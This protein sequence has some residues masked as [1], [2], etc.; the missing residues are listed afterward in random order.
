VKPA[1]FEYVR[2]ETVAD[3]VGAL[4]AYSGGARVLA[5]GQSLVPMLNMRLWQPR[6]L[7]DINDV[8]ELDHLR[9]ESDRVVVGAL[10]R[11]STLERSPEVAQRIPLVAEMVRSIGD[12]QVRNRGTAGGALGQADPTGEF[13]LACLTLDATVVT[14][15]PGGARRVPLRELYVG[16]Y[17]SALDPEELIVAVEIPDQPA[18][19]S[20]GEICRRHNDFA[21]VSVAAAGT[22]ANDGTWHDVRVA[23]GGV[24][25]TALRLDGVEE[26]L[27][28]TRLDDPL[29]DDASRR[30]LDVIDPPTDIRATADYRRHLTPVQIRRVLTRLRNGAATVERQHQ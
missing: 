22:R 4:A 17:V 19:H 25:D 11:Y 13:I 30:A 3:A 7:V 12:R 8:D 6:A 9:V 14:I 20:F 10:V 2:P 26:A 24:A 16:S 23:V 21:V 1:V 5:G 28:G 29:I 18:H 15:G 27:T